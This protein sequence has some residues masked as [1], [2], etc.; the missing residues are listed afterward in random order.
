MKLTTQEEYGLRCL[1][2]L[3]RQGTRASLTISEMSQR[4]GI[5]SPNVA[6][7]MRLLRRAS[8]LTSTRGKAGG[9]TLSRPASQ[10]TVS[11]VLSALGGRLWDPKFCERHAGGSKECTNLGECSIRPVLRYVQEAVDHVLAKLSLADLLASEQEVGAVVRP[12]SKTIATGRLR[13]A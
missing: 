12:R 5:S 3:A 2:Q 7:I 1:L 6:K 4:E 9:Y 10:I 11:E 13:L 8:L